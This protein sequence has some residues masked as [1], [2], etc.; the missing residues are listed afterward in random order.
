MS[1]NEKRVPKRR[2]KEFESAGEWEQ[3]KLGEFGYFYYGKSAPK[4]SVTQDARTPCVRYGELYTKHLEKIDKIYSYTNIPKDNLKFSTGKEVLVPRVGEDPLDFANCSWLS[5]P[6]VAIGEMISVYNTEQN[7]LFTAY[8]FNA[9]LK[10]EFAKRVEGGNVSNLY[11]AYLEDIHVSFPSIDEQEKIAKFLSD[12]SNLITIHQRKLDKMKALKKAYLTDMFPAEGEHKPKLRFA[13]FTDD[14]EQRKLGEI[15]EF[16][17]EQRKPLESGTRESGEYPYYGASGII[18]YVK[19]YLFN[20]E[21]ILLSE[22]GANIVDRNYRVCFLASGKYWVNNHAHVLK[23]KDN[24]CNGFICEALERL[25][26]AQYNTG[27]AQPKL[28]QQVCRNIIIMVPNLE[29][30]QRIS[31]YLVNLDKLIT[32]HQRKLEKLQN[33]KKA[34]LN[35][36]FI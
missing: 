4:W 25:D 1:G 35:E 20:E 36:M 9:L 5:I 31:S 10:Y 6:N 11:Y 28:N 27:T 2:F 16:L 19:D 21:L 17:D 8:M 15:V 26:Y 24:Y 33:I 34:Y 14:W 32:L 13:G 30:Q 7:P 29:E 3:R 23:S 12:I 22:D 18:D